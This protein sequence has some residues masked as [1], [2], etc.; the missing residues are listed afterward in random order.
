MDVGPLA[1]VSPDTFAA[2]AFSPGNQ[3]NDPFPNSGLMAVTFAA[4]FV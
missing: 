1:G 3:P 4:E 2:V